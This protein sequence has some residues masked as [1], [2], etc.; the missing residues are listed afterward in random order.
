M[1]VRRDDPANPAVA[2]ML[3][4]HVAEQHGNVP[5]GFAFALDAGGLA[6]PDITFWT[7]WVGEAL[8]GFGA[9][10]QLDDHAGEVK[11]MRAAPP[12]RGQGA[13]HAILSAIIAEARRRG[14]ARL[15]LET[16]TSDFYVPAITLYRRA[17]FVPCPPFADY[18]A[19]PH[20][21]FFALDLRES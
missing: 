3:A 13:G 2:P 1:E 10:K 8:A 14:L 15:Y 21:Q 7:A 20:N 11:S 19:S 5:P 16:G 18:A 17:G 12:F 9:L 4:A 6:S